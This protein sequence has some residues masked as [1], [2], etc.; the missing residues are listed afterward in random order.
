MRVGNYADL[1]EDCTPVMES[2]QYTELD[3]RCFVLFIQYSDAQME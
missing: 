3:R 2:T 1:G